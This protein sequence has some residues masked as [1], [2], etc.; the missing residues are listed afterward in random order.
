MKP[1]RLYIDETGHHTYKTLDS[2]D[3]RYLGLTGVLIRQKEYREKVNPDLEQL[4]REIFKYDPDDPPIL[5]RSLLKGKKSWFYVLQDEELNKRWE[6]SILSYLRR[7]KGYTWF[8]TIVIDKKKHKKQYPIET[9]EAYGYSL[10]VLLNRVRG[11]LQQILKGEQAEIIAESRGPKED[12]ELQRA[13]EYLR[14]V[15]P[16]YSESG[17]AE[18]YCEAFPN[19]KLMIKGKY[20]NI[21]GLQIADIVAVGQK[22]LTI[23]ENKKALEKPIA[24]F[25]S[26]INEAIEPMVWM[27][28][29]RYMLY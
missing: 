2:F 23:Q 4:K 11:Y 26:K 21:T 7:L 3:K 18:Q 15:G 28:Y 6:E 17:T 24:I 25:D 10:S 9:F 27:P 13:Y 22:M 8:Y 16:S 20:Q 14:T 12:K 5:V 19:P 29:G 1:W